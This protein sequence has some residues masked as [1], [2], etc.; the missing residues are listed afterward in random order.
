[1]RYANAF[2]HLIISDYR[3]GNNMSNKIK[4]EAG[5]YEFETGI[6]DSKVVVNCSK[7]YTSAY[8]FGFKINP[9]KA[10]ELAR[11]LNHFA[12]KLDEK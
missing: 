1:M 6:T 8:G 3:A 5:E 9:Q 12:D 11:W 4:F 7:P 2:R 10:R